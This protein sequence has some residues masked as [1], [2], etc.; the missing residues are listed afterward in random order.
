MDT[1]INRP[2]VLAKLDPD[3]RTFSLIYPLTLLA[4]KHGWSAK[5]LD[6]AEIELRVLLQLHRRTPDLRLPPATLDTDELLH[7]WMSSVGF[8]RQCTQLFGYVIEHDGLAGLRG[9]QD[10]HD[11]R[12]RV[13]ACLHRRADFFRCNHTSDKE[14]LAMNELHPSLADLVARCHQQASRN[15]LQRMINRLRYKKREKELRFCVFGRPG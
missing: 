11:Q 7:V 9:A 4:I 2:C 12:L 14:H 6:A 10:A 1:P 8:A 3:L 13:E 15:P 5:R